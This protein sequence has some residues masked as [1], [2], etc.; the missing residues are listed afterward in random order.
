MI[1][2]IS[3]NEEIVKLRRDR[4]LGERMREKKR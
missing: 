3:F 4:E 1:I 2:Y